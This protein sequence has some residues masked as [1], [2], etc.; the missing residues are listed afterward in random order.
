MVEK[1]SPSSSSVRTLPPTVQVSKPSPQGTAPKAKPQGKPPVNTSSIPF[2]TGL[3]VS[4]AWV[5]IVIIA[6]AASGS[7]HTF[8]G[9]P[10]V[11][12][13]IGVSAIVSPV[14]LVWMV[15]AYLQRA[16]DIQTITDPL[17]RQLVL[18]TGESG[19]A[20]ARI[21]RF[22][23]AIK[24]QLD[25]LRSAQSMS[26]QDLA[27]IMDRVSQH[28]NELE[29]FEHA[30]INQVKEIQEIIRRNMQQVEHLM[31]DKFTML[32]VLDDKLVQSGDSVA[33]Q[34]E[35][36]RD[37]VVKL[38][39]EIESNSN[40]MASALDRA[41]QDSRKLADT[42]RAQESSLLTAAESAAE[43]LGGV[44]SKIDLSVARFLERAGSAREEAER[45]AG[46]LET[47]TRSLDEF[48]NT[49][50]ARV[51]EAEAVL[52]G[53]ADRLYASEQA[54]REQAVT[55]SE[56]L[57][58]QV[59]GLEKFLERFTGRL[60]HIDTSLDQRRTD[61][62][63]LA[64]RI[65]D[66]TTNFVQAWEQSITDL[67]QRTAGTLERF[68]GANDEARKGAQ[69]VAAHL[70]ETTEKY[71]SITLRV[72]ALSGESNEKLKGMTN[73]IVSYLSQFEAL[74]EAS[75]KAGEEVQSRAAA[76]MQNLQ[77]VLERLLTAR[78]A[79]QNVGATLVKDLYTAVDQ[80]EQLI[81]RLND[82]SQMSVRALGIA[83]ESLGK[84]EGE[85]AIQARSAEAMLQQATAQL[86]QQAQLAETGLRE[87][88]N[89][90]M[91][92]L[93]DT[94]NQMSLTD[95]KLQHF[96]VNAITP[97]QSAVNNID[98]SA[99]IGMQTMTRYGEGLQEQVNRLQQFTGRV[100]GMSEDISRVSLE[101]VTS[102]EQLNN[103]FN[104][105]RTVQEETARQTLTQFGELS[106]RLQREITGFDSQTSQAVDL[107]QQAAA[108]V[109]EQSYQLLQNAQSTGTQIQTVTSALQSEATQIRAVLQ[110]QA[111]DL[112]AD[113]TR[114]ERQF[115]TL[116]ETLKQR[117][118]AAYALLDRVAT[119]YNEVTRTTAQDLETRTQRLEQA[120]A[121]ANSKVET[122]SATLTQQL[123]LIGNGSS[124]LEANA[125]QLTTANGKAIQQLSALNEK[126]AITSE[127]ANNNA[128][129]TI[130]RIDECNTAFMRQANS[131]AEASQTS[132]TL[133]QKAGM[134][135]GEQAGKMLDTSHQMEQNLRQLTATTSALADQSAQIRGNMEQQNQRLIA[136][137]TEAVAQLDASSSKLDQSVAQATSGADQASARFSEMTQNA[138]SRL[139]DSQQEV[140]NVASKTETTLAALG[141]NITQQASSLSIVGEQ[142]N[143]QYRVLS[144][145]NENQRTQLVD[146]F[147]KL[148]SAHSQSAEVAERTI[149]RLN[150]A[151]AQIQRNLGAL[152]DQSQTAVGN[153]RTASSGFADQCGVLLQNAQQAEQQARTVLTVTAALQ[154]QARQLREALHGEGER[155]SEIFGA[156]VSKISAG[157]V[158]LREFSSS[159][160][161]VLTSL[162]NNMAS[163]GA[164]LNNTMQQI[165]D[166]QRSLT[167]A[168]DAQRDVING[169]LNRLA[170]AQD[171]TASN[172]ER[173][174]A[175]LTDGAQQ[176]A[177][178]LE[179]IGSQ[180]QNTLAN[181]HA[182]SAGFA[183]EAGSLG[184]HA[185]QAEQQMRAV[186]SVTAGMQEQARQLRESMQG[187]TA[188]VIEQLNSVISQLDSTNSQ[189]KLQGGAAIHSMD[190]SALQFAAITRSSGDAMQKQAEA[191][192]QTA[193]QA[194][195]RMANAGEKIRGHLKL[196]SDIGDQTE[197]RANQ[198]ADTA[199]FAAT[200]LATLR[201]TMTSADKDGQSTLMQASLR[202]EAVKAALQ[203]E[204]Q[205]LSQM[206]QQ[207][208][209]QVASASQ[210]LATQS[211]VLRANL[212]SSESALVEAANLVREES[213]NVP[214]VINRSTASLGEAMETLKGQS[215]ETQETL[216]KT[217]D[218]FISVT[219]TARESMVDE[220][221]R[222]STVADEA[223]KV[224]RLFNQSFA[225]Q[226]ATMQKGAQLLTGEQQ[227]LVEKASDSVRQLAAASDRLAQLRNDATQTAEKLARE[228]DTI[229]QR[230]TATQQR[231]GQ[232]GEAVIKTIDTLATAADRAEAQMLGASS[233]FREQLERIRTGIQGQ[234]DDINRGLMQITAQL[235]RTGNT[236]RSTTVG[237]VADVERVSQRFEQT[238]KEAGDQLV[239]KTARMRG[240]TEE[241]ASLLSGFGDQ[242]D[243]LLD[244]LS[245][246]GDGIRRNE[247]N[248]VGQ[249]QTAL[250]H[251]S[252]VAERLESGRSLTTNVTEQAVGRL[253]EVAE[254]I[255]KQMQNLTSGSQTIAGVMRG[256]SQIYGDQTQ[257]M[258]KNVHEA[259]SQVMGMNKAIDDMQQRTDRM[260]VSLKMQGEELMNSLQGILSQLGNTGDALSDTVDQVV[261]DQADSLKKIG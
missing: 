48:S 35:S 113:L 22:N 210:N 178:Q 88:A 240:A 26:R 127:A 235:E 76:A 10:L 123:S 236:L 29:R 177:K 183:D 255:Q 248:I 188:R 71:E 170:L 38:L 175:R 199:E 184:L 45:L 219:T 223:D 3:L 33:R 47:Q 54:A 15:A 174:V 119:H 65:G 228:F 186:L 32:R 89:N 132:V 160:E 145:A 201:D 161:M 73:E 180:A 80:N 246:A 158:E 82:A 98:A 69:L 64:G 194:E 34:T 122:L 244:R 261:R 238:S 83:S 28:R 209:Q 61:L 249:M 94:Q 118:D 187:E 107:L 224:L 49:L 104:A 63:G 195:A 9:I 79:T 13:A 46:A 20:E 146:L 212:A 66:T 58:V 131:L 96:A 140:Q 181:V 148:G 50:P 6:V 139:K 112:S 182:A 163:Q 156:L 93:A 126:L 130:T 197:E 44:S 90:L 200:R 77:H 192:S 165:S 150:D 191:L 252:T 135:F 172:A 237:A 16:T 217:T 18:I 138:T 189:L 157:G 62:D 53:V 152:S 19:A 149:A 42:S 30:S 41:M 147:D 225:E 142:L 115:E 190:Q 55:L 222:V 230:A 159:T 43:T 243:V 162:Q 258:N 5:G 129:Q 167:V 75:H 214:S 206:S 151:L 17:R 102:I 68:T 153:V 155:T 57:S 7:A 120:T 254:A 229:D 67:N 86:Q 205:R 97:I 221:R 128:Q 36:V 114:A 247:G 227:H 134:S 23:Q 242:L 257:S 218:R 198:L 74:R 21:R 70:N 100:T 141:A 27:T 231:L 103:R 105:V 117:T 169:L 232:T 124:Q 215:E 239:D 154:E 168:L 60:A 250:S 78:E 31:D 176:I 259:H 185:Q 121:Q 211:D 2:W 59:D 164:S 179:V 111:D 233:S 91:T 4:L 37:Q 109:G 136:Q 245:V 108:R 85:L 110:K 92:L 196:V 52:R 234:I 251:L 137:L 241:V 51:S 203:D 24:E 171:E 216:V 220:M 116:G 213:V 72:R 101:S 106:D 12:W 8:G 173:T 14:A 144:G 39:E 11:N 208:V 95:Q 202:I 84:Q 81:T 143:E 99:E 166:R 253:N 87:Q 25:L 125:S 256:I 226:V 204:L 1:K 207:A 40:Q 193:D 56:K 260:R 133:I